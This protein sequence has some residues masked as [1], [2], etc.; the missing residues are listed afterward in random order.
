MRN[1]NRSSLVKAAGIIAAV[2]LSP[3]VQSDATI[4][5]KDSRGAD[6]AL[7]QIKGNMVR[8][9]QPGQA[10]YMLYDKTR[11]TVIH[12]RT[13]QQEYMEIDRATIDRY[14]GTIS[15]MREQIAPQIAMMREQLKNMP[16]EQ[17]AM[18]EQRMG[19]MVDLGTMDSQPADDIRTVK[20]GSKTVSGFDCDLYEVLNGG[21]PVAEVCLAT[22]ADAGMSDA[23]FDTLSAMMAFTRDMAGKA[24][25]LAA[26]MT[27]GVPNLDIGDAQGVPV[28]MKDLKQGREFSVAGVSDDKLDDA[29]FSAYKSYRKKEMPGIP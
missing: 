7:I 3:T 26:G 24:Q 16:P 11:D 20:R 19:G 5:M 1:I 12:V 13:A 21:Q 4:R 23:D 25:K 28:A 15:A 14:A 22:E 29:V 18:I 2:L 27:T 17:R 8:M 10:D 9:S 6:D